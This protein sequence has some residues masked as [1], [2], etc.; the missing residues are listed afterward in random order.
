LK[1][2]S[3]LF[4]EAI[5]LAGVEKSSNYSYLG[6][7]LDLLEY[8]KYDNAGELKEAIQLALIGKSY[9]IETLKA[10]INAVVDAP[11]GENNGDNGDDDGGYTG[12]GGGG[13]GGYSTG[14][15]NVESNAPVV[16][17]SFTDVSSS[18]WAFAAISNLRDRKIIDGFEDNSYRPDN[19]LTRAEAVKL[20]CRAFN[21]DETSGESVFSDVKE[22]DWYAPC[23]NAA[24]KAGFVNGDGTAFNPNNNI[25]R[26]DLCVMIYR[27]AQGNLNGDS[28]D[29]ADA[30]KISEYAKQAVAALSSSGIINGFEDKTFRPLATATRAQMA[31]MLYKYLLMSAM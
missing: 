20:L 25:T 8:S 24:Y 23:I 29:Y 13:G 16:N 6:S 5:V 14:M 10:A 1:G 7:Y 30:Q 18:H 31:Q 19:S 4:T 9:T 22:A 17:T 12:G 15:S 28:A 27:F 3:D 26:Q 11:Q 2:Y 21:I